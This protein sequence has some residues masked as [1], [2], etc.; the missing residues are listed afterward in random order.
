MPYPFGTGAN[1]TKPLD[2][3]SQTRWH[4]TT[5][6]TGTGRSWDDPCSLAFA[7]ANCSDSVTD[8][9]LLGPGTYDA[10]VA[11]VGWT[12]NKR[13]V[14]IQGLQTQA[15]TVLSNSHAG[16]TVGVQV[17]A[18]NVELWD[19]FFKPTGSQTGL[20]T[21]NIQEFRMTRC[22]FTGTGASETGL[23]LEN[24]S[25]AQVEGTYIAG[26]GNVGLELDQAAQII[27]ERNVV[28][29]SA[30]GV[31]FTGVAESFMSVTQTL[32]A[33]CTV[34]IEV[35]GAGTDNIVVDQVRMIQNGTNIDDSAAT[36]GSVTFFRIDTESIVTK[37]IPTGAGMTVTS[38]A[39]NTYGAKGT[40]AASGAIP[41]PFIITALNIQDIDSSATYT[42]K[43]WFGDTVSDQEGPEFQWASGLSFFAVPQ[44]VVTGSGYIFPSG[45][46]VEGA[47]KAIDA[48]TNS[49]TFSITYYEI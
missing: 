31:R 27:L 3:L 11:G 18:N 29:Q 25:A 37:V 2:D 20:H 10:N 45:T 49:G 44:S 32:I 9:I 16:A 24:T 19:L 38:G 4:V 42:F 41:K 26:C 35:G 47:L 30:V 46:L 40:L 8:L 28:S 5:T 17:T 34:G 1:F 13:N 43:G 22:R 23:K 7:L 39:V 21:L 48:A 14:T 12:I 36:W 33:Y 15:E 6:G